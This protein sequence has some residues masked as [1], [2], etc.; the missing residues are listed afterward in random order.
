MFSSPFLA[1]IFPFSFGVSGGGGGGMAG[2]CTGA[3]PQGN[4]MH[5]SIGPVGTHC[6]F[7]EHSSEGS[8]A[9]GFE[10]MRRLH[11]PWVEDPPPNTFG[12]DF[13]QGGK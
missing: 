9:L 6:T 12:M 3:G 8:Y 2:C 13:T 1:L 11:T 7:R 5:H 4:G 10:P